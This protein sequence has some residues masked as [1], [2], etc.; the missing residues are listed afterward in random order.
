MGR[1]GELSQ[2]ELFPIVL[3]SY[4]LNITNLTSSPNILLGEEEK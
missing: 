3:P 4:K 1:R 2:L